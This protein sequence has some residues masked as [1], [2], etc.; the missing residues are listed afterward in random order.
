MVFERLIMPNS[1]RMNAVVD[2]QGWGYLTDLRRGSSPCQTVGATLAE[3]E[4]ILHILPNPNQHLRRATYVIEE[5][6]NMAGR[7]NSLCYI[8]TI[9]LE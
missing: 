4:A 6:W 8:T 5:D 1:R 3:G 2:G 9:D 7:H